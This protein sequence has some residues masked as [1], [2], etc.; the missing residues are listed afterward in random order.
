MVRVLVLSPYGDKLLPVFGGEEEVMFRTHDALTH[1]LWLKPDWVV[2][3][4]YRKIIPPGTIA[5]CKNP[6]I[7]IHIGYLPWN[8]GASPNLWSWYEGTPSGVT[9]HEV[10][11]GIDTGRILA[12]HRLYNTNE[13]H[14]LRS[15]Y[16]GL[17]HLATDL[18]AA[19][20]RR[21][22]NGESEPYAQEEGGS[23]HTKAQTEELMKQ[24]PL[25]WDTPIAD[26][27][28]AGKKSR[29]EK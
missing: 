7:N 9:I 3:Y 14:T 19:N 22:R 24:F 29:E 17:H 27:I 1:I 11:E 10:D 20:W 8:R 25:G 23:Y 4:G 12:R 2:M 13:R 18:F 21:I 5:S 6:I 15:F 28:E 16:E 26:V